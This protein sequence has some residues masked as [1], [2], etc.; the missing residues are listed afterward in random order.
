MAST[1]SR[2]QRR[3]EAVNH[4]ATVI[5]SDMVTT[6]EIWQQGQAMVAQGVRWPPYVKAA[7]KGIRNQT[8]LGNILSRHPDW[9]KIDGGEWKGA[10]RINGRLTQ[11]WRRR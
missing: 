3:R 1:Q 7:W 5:G 4:I 9:E 8:T 11:L 6:N 2:K 10:V